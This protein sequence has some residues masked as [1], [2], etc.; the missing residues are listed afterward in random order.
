MLSG[1]LFD[2]DG[3]LYTTENLHQA[4]VKRVFEERFDEIIDPEE[5]KAFVGLPYYDRLLHLFAARGI[6]DDVLIEEL[7]EKAVATTRAELDYESV[8]VPGARELLELAKKN[9]LRM[10][11]VS[12]TTHANIHERLEKTDLLRFFDLLVGRDDV[13][14]KKP[15]PEPY[16]H[17]LRSLGLKPNEAVAFEDS[18]VGIESARLAGIP[19]VALLTTY[20]Q[21]ELEHAKKYIRDYTG[22]DVAALRAVVE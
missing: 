12:S 11:V 2:L 4:V 1:L 5:M 3:T 18:A 13:K 10:A 14:I 19:V 21:E 9:R 16:E 8:V 17:A 7:V 22:V 20:H 15:H 6:D